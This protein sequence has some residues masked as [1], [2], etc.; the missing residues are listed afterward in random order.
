MVT[1][2][3]E[4]QFDEPPAVPR[5]LDG[6]IAVV[7]GVSRRRGIGLA[8]TRRLLALGARI[9]AQSWSEYD[10]DRPYGPD[11]GGADAAVA[12]L[13]ARE[14]QLRDIA[15]DLGDP[16]SPARLVNEA[17]TTFGGID[18]LVVNHTRTSQQSL[19]AMTAAELDRS[20]AV[21]TR[22]SLLLV[23]AY[24]NA[25]DDG[26][27]GRIVLFTSGQHLAPMGGD[28]PY[29]VT[30]GAIHQITLTLS[31]VLADRGITVNA[32]NPGPT[33]TGWAPPELIDRLAPA[34][35]AG[36]WGAPDDAARLVAWLVSDEAAWITGQVINSEGGFRRWMGAT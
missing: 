33:D 21:N 4:N 36:R 7:T 15:L 29:A 10:R 27:P 6:R 24:A 11:P 25:H 34:F 22:A 14:D 12:E 5:P 31:D 17:V 8:L 28:L 32:I 30:K 35:P 16:G 26:R 1:N 18:I 20:W 19:Q 13:G 2:D 23:Q 3:A 9:L